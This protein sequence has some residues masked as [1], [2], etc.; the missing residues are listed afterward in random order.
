MEQISVRNVNRRGRGGEERE[1]VG[2]HDVR[3]EEEEEERKGKEKKRKR[4]KG[5]RRENTHPLKTTKP[6]THLTS[7]SLPGPTLP[8]SGSK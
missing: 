7:L 6:S 3:K 2:E 1:G 5:K 8:L 4:K